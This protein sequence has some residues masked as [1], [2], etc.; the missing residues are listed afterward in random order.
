R[1]GRGGA[2]RHPRARADLRALRHPDWHSV[3]VPRRPA[4]RD[5]DHETP[6]VAVKPWLLVAGDFTPL[7]GMD[8]AN[9][10]LATH[11]AARGDVHLVTHRAW[12]DLVAL[13]TV[14][15]HRV[16]RPFGSHALGGVLLSR[17][18]RRTWRR[19]EPR[20]LH[21]VANGG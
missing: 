18:G 15:V 5:H 7:G 17:E 12:A 14:T 1:G 4:P 8:I 3:L 16:P 10:A 21:A 19:L 20:G 9:H 2:Y 13:P 11:L 6:V